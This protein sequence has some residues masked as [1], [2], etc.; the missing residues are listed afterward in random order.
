MLESYIKLPD[1]TGAMT[2]RNGQSLYEECGPINRYS[3]HTDAGYQL[4]ED[5]RTSNSTYVTGTC[6]KFFNVYR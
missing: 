6:S 5:G 3:I 1:N 4:R 2:A